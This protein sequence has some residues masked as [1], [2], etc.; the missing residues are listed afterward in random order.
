MPVRETVILVEGVGNC[1]AGTVIAGVAERVMLTETVRVKDTVTLRVKAWVVGIPVRETV[2]HPV[3]LCVTDTD[4]V[5]VPET[6]RVKGWVD[7]MPV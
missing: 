2:P 7:G 4:R 6:D 1:E 3:T 5:R